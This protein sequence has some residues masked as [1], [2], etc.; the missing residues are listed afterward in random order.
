[1]REEEKVEQTE[2]DLLEE[3]QGGRRGRSREERAEF[4]DNI[5]TLR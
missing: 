3:D 4:R 5:S 1:M 2:V